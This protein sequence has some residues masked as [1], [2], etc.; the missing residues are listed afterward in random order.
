MAKYAGADVVAEVVAGRA[1]RAIGYITS[2]TQSIGSSAKSKRRGSRCK[3][4]AVQKM[5]AIDSSF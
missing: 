3:E 2:H 5:A 1:S 4:V